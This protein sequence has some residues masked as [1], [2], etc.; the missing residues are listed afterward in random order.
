M[1]E[2]QG[3]SREGRGKWRNVEKNVILHTML[4]RIPSGFWIMNSMALLV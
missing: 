1:I 3:G 4:W 2:K